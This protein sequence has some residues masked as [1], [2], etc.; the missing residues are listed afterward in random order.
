MFPPGFSQKISKPLA[1]G[2]L[3]ALLGSVSLPLSSQAQVPFQQIHAQLQQDPSPLGSDLE[4]RLAPGDQIRIENAEGREYSG[5][6]VIPRDGNISLP[7]VGTVGISGLTIKDATELLVARYQRFF[8][9]PQIGL[10]LIIPRALNIVI[11]GEV[12]FPGAYTIPVQ[13]TRF[14][15]A[16][17]PPV[18]QALQLAGGVNLAANL[19]QVEVRR[20]SVNAPPQVITLDLWAFLER[21]DASQNIPLRDGDTIFV[22][23]ADVINIEELR[24]QATTNFSSDPNAA[25][26]VVVVGEVQR[27]GTYIIKGGETRSERVSEGLPTVTRALQLAGGVTATAD[28]REVSIRRLTHSGSEQTLTV[29]LWD[30][31]QLGA[32]SEDTILQDGDTIVVPTA[33]GPNLEETREILQTN[34]AI[35]MTEPRT[36]MVVGAVTRPG[37]Y[38]VQGGDTA[39]DRVSFV[40]LPSVTRAIQLAGGILPEADVRQVQIKRPTKAGGEQLVNVDLWQLLQTGNR[41]LDPIVA[42]GDTIVVPL[43]SESNPKESAELA[44]SSFAPE[45]IQVYVVGEVGQIGNFR[46][47]PVQ[48][49]GNTTLNQALLAA[50]GFQNSRANQSSVDLIR[51]NPNGTVSYRTILVNFED[52]INEQSNPLLRD[53]DMIIVERSRI[54]RFADTLQTSLG[55]V[56]TLR[57]V[58]DV[59]FRIL[60]FL[61]F[62]GIFRSPNR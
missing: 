40:G 58:V 8:K 2:S 55:S 33:A 13:D 42:E 6:F 56:V 26:T 45:F 43:A 1:K 11:S 59:P 21:G 27:P 47:E 5:D 46:R 32:V 9:Y 17:L 16:Q 15:G 4:Y 23:T 3:L 34:F 62:L 48:L 35:P 60:E 36:V 28:I 54:A 25:R 38:V 49:P 10:S 37:S 41:S 29:N 44:A 39:V 53:N 24:R 31:L 51:V 20:Q 7:L 52:P 57:Q 22:P 50:G 12:S 30:F 18:T 19:R 61:Q 14:P